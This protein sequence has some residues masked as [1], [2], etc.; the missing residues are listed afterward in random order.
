LQFEEFNDTYQEPMEEAP[1]Y[2]TRSLEKEHPITS[3]Y[4]S[5][6]YQP[7]DCLSQENGKWVSYLNPKSST[8]RKSNPL[9]VKSRKL[10]NQGQSSAQRE[11][12]RS[13]SRSK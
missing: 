12:S 1:L 8:K 11:K 6:K 3:V 10:S 4:K 9:A 13:R 7:A 5:K 2:E